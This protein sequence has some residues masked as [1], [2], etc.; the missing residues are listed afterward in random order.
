MLKILKQLGKFVVVDGLGVEFEVVEASLLLPYSF[1]D[2]KKNREIERR[3]NLNDGTPL[4]RISW[5]KFEREGEVLVR[6]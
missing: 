4:R 2:R 3:F 5:N 6:K 1:N